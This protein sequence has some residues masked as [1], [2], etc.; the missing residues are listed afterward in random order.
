[1]KLLFFLAPIACLFASCVPILPPAQA[2]YTP[3]A[4]T[5]SPAGVVVVDQRNFVMNGEKN[6][7]YIGRVRGAY[8]IPASVPDPEMTFAERIAGYAE[9]GLEQKG[10]KVIRKSVAKGTSS[11]E[12]GRSF[13]GTG[14]RKILVL[15]LNDLWCDFPSLPWSKTANVYFD[16]TADVVTPEG[17]VVG[18]A[19]RKKDFNFQVTDGNDSLYNHLLKA[20]QPEFK[21]IIAAPSVRSGLQ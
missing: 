2:P 5:A 15:R 13:Q 4:P 19:R 10:A 16:V 14:A 17:R 1:M 11:S 8:G 18:S 6:E 12:I 9:A 7:K 21:N 20:L 3:A